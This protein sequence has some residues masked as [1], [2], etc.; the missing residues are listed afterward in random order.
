M[1]RV[2]TIIPLGRA[3]TKTKGILPGN[4]D[5]AVGTPQP[6]LSND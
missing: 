2:P 4:L 6:G 1:E 5:V 3:S